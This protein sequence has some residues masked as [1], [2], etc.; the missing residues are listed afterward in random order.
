MYISW[1][2]TLS[3]AYLNNKE[4][5]DKELDSCHKDIAEIRKNIKKFNIKQNPDENNTN[6]FK[7]LTKFKNISTKKYE[8]MS[9]LVEKYH[10]KKRYRPFHM[11]TCINSSKLFLAN[12]PL[13][14][15]H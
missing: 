12:Y 13:I 15:K 4:D 2:N 7:N 3:F 9:E 5:I 8:Q 1:K 14:M 11:M 10:D 6:P